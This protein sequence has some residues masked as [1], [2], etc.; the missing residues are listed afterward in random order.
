VSTDFNSDMVAQHQTIEAPLVF[1]TIVTV[2]PEDF[3]A[4]LEKQDQPL[5]VVHKSGFFVTEYRYLTSYKG[6][7]FSTKSGEQLP[8]S[9]RTELIQARSMYLPG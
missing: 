3:K 5:V 9:P 1:A 7:S 2:G 4:I 8:L 6:L